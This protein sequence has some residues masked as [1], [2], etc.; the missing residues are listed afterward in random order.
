MATVTDTV[1]RSLRE[2]LILTDTIRCRPDEVS[3]ETSLGEQKA[4][5]LQYPYMTARMQSVVGPQMAC[6]AGRNGILTCVPQ[7]LR[8]EDKQQILDANK[9]ARLKTGDV[10][11]VERPER[12]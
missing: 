3:L 2:F 4:I 6:T 12:V 1:S 5:K 8:D 10:Q 9:A 11:Y 7:S